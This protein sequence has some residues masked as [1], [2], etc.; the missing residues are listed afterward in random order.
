MI[1]G[2]EAPGVSASPGHAVGRCDPQVPTTLARPHAA[3]SGQVPSDQGGSG[4]RRDLSPARLPFEI[5]VTMVRLVS[6][7]V[8]IQA[9]GFFLG[10]AVGLSPQVVGVAGAVDA[11][12]GQGD[13]VDGGVE[14][15][16][17]AAG[18][19]VAVDG[20]RGCRDG[21]GAG[22]GGVAVAGGKAG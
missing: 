14:L 4:N 7:S 13:A 16:V 15:A 2:D 11:D 8:P 19:P 6:C 17:A 9:D 1:P 10:L 12:L 20:A 21:R 18:E 5:S 3:L 22:V